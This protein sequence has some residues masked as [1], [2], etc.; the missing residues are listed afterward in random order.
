MV[1]IIEATPFQVDCAVPVT[2]FVKLFSRSL[3][4][5]RP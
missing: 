3:D 4:V 1:V 5:S 2:R